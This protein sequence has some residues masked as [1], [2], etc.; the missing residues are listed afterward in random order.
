MVA[1]KVGMSKIKKRIR[2]KM[3]IFS[4][5]YLQYDINF[6]ETSLSYRYQKDK[7]DQDPFDRAFTY[8]KK[9]VIQL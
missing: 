4:K 2:N 9:V 1:S 6:L 5:F 7:K 8:P 3:V